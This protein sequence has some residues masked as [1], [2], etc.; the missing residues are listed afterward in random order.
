[1]SQKGRYAELF[2]TQSKYYRESGLN[3]ELSNDMQKNQ[4]EGCI[5]E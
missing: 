5:Y 2:E 1:M 3:S 4:E